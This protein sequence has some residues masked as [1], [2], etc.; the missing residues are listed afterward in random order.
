MAHRPHSNVPSP[1]AGWRTW[2]AFSWFRTDHQHR[3][4]TRTSSPVSALACVI[5][6]G[7]FSRNYLDAACLS[8]RPFTASRQLTSTFPRTPPHSVTAEETNALSEFSPDRYT[9]ANSGSSARFRVYGSVLDFSS[10]HQITADSRH[11]GISAS[12]RARRTFS[13]E[14]SPQ[15][16]PR[17]RAILQIHFGGG[18]NGRVL[19]WYNPKIIATFFTSSI[20]LSYGHSEPPSN[21]YGKYFRFRELS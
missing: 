3:S 17:V 15:W 14:C 2:M 11:R 18:I 21:I 20:I 1:G 4:A 12:G 6:A 16:E 19:R 9:V 5:K 8:T 7:M 13:T 10:F